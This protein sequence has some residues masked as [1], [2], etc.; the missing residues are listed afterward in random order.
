M[1]DDVIGRRI[2]VEYCLGRSV[3]VNW[4]A[5]HVASNVNNRILMDRYDR[6]V[7]PRSSIAAMWSRS[8]MIVLCVWRH[9]DGYYYFVAMALRS[10]VVAT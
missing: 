6:Y 5:Q 9:S 7:L 8:C 2:I 4:K 1:E 3:F 10:E